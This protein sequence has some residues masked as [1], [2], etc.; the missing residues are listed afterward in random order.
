[1]LYFNLDWVFTVTL[2][3]KQDTSL[4]THGLSPSGKNKDLKRRF[5]LRLF[6]IF[7]LG[8]IIILLAWV[9]ICQAEA[10]REISNFQQNLEK[11]EVEYTFTLL[12]LVRDPALASD[13]QA[14]QSEF[15][16]LSPF[17]KLNST[18][19]LAPNGSILASSQSIP[20]ED[21]PPHSE[22]ILRSSYE[23]QTYWSSGGTHLYVTIPLL[24]KNNQLAATLMNIHNHQEQIDAFRS[25][26]TLR[27]T[28][29]I[30]LN[31]AFLLLVYAAYSWFFLRPL[32]RLDHQARAIAQGAN[33]SLSSGSPILEIQNLDA[34][35]AQIIDTMNE[36]RNSLVSLNQKLEETIAAQNQ[37]L[38][39][40]STTIR[41]RARQLETLNAAIATAS[42]TLNIQSLVRTNL[43]QIIQIVDASKGVIWLNEYSARLGL[44]EGGSRLLL[45]AIKEQ[46]FDLN[47]KVTISDWQGTVPLPVMSLVPTMLNLGIRASITLPIFSG[48]KL[49]GHI[50]VGDSIPRIWR[51]EEIALL[52]IVASQL[53][54]TSER[55]QAIEEVQNHNQLMNTLVAQSELLN[56]PFTPAEVIAAIGQGARELSKA[57]RLAVFVRDTDG[58]VTCPW[59]HNF[60]TPIPVGLLSEPEKST[61]FLGLLK[62]EPIFI[63][64]LSEAVHQ[65]PYHELAQAAGIQSIAAWPLVYKGQ[66]DAFVCCLYH[67]P[68]IWKKSEQEVLE[69]FFRQ[70]SVAMENTRLFEAECAQRRLAEALTEVTST[71]TSTLD[72][73]K[74]LQGILDNLIRV[75]PHHAADIML[76]DNG[77]IRIVRGYGHPPE[78]EKEMMQWVYP[79]KDLFNM[80]EMI[81][82]GKSIVIPD[83]SAAPDWVWFPFSEW[84]RSYA[85]API[86]H[87]GNVLGFINVSSRIPGFFSLEIGPI[88]EAFANQAAISIENARLYQQTQQ[89]VAETS[90]L[91][92]AVLPLFNPKEDLLALARQVT[93]SATHEFAPAHCSLLLVNETHT[94]LNLVA[95]SGY[96]Q[97][98]STTLSL[99]GSGLTVEAAT[100]RKIVYAPDIRKE[101]R[102]V[103]GAKETRSELVIPLIAQDHVIGV[104]NL[105]SPET[106]AFDEN[107]RRILAS[108]AERTALGLE[109]ARLFQAI[110]EHAAQMIYLNDITRI[111]LQTSDSQK[112]LRELTYKVAQMIDADGCYI[113][114]WD[115]TTSSTI[116]LAAYGPKQDNYTSIKPS[117]ERTITSAALQEGHPLV[118]A[119]VHQTPYL[120]AEMAETFPLCSLLALPLVANHQKMGAVLIGFT[121]AHTFMPNEIALGEQAAGQIA[122]AMAKQRS[123]E[124]AQRRAQEAETLRQATMSLT[125]SLELQKVLDNILNHL[126]QV[127]Q[128]DSACVF[129]AEPDYL[130]I[131]SAKNIGNFEEIKKA[132]FP[133]NDEL[134]Q[135]IENTLRP[136]ILP[137]AQADLRFHSWGGITNV[138]SWMGVPLIAGNA[139]V[140]VLT[141]DRNQANA[142][143]TEEM[144]LAQAF[145]NHA[146]IAV[147]NA[148][149]Y[150]ATQQ[151]ARE[152]QALHSAT[153]SLVSTLDLQKLLEEILASARSAIPAAQAA[154]LHLLNPDSGQLQL[155]VSHGFSQREHQIE[156]TQGMQDFWSQILQG[157]KPVMIHDARLLE[158][159]NDLSP[160]QR[161]ERRA[162]AIIAPL[163]QEE[164][165]IGVLS[166]I[167]PDTDAFSETDLRLLV[168]F[169][170]TATA[171]IQNAQLHSA[172][173]HLA[174]TDPLTGVYNRRGFSELA[175]KIICCTKRNQRPLS[176]MM[177]DID[178]FKLVNDRY[179]HDIGDHIL[180]SLAE[181]CQMILRE[182][183]IICRYG[184]EE[185]AVLLP[186]SDVQGTQIA[187]ERLF[188]S[189]AQNP[190]QT[191]CGA[192][193]I[194]LSIGIAGY[195]EKITTL[196]GILK[197]AD[198]AL[199]LAKQEG[200]NRIRIWK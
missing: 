184:G 136:V 32:R 123:L 175:H 197:C 110:R 65:D 64:D 82:T 20:L 71:L 18:Y 117:Q 187:A 30:A 118:V 61:H 129:L 167:S 176:A 121:E 170:S 186:D 150:L 103:P 41:Q 70:A 63:P 84:I 14:V 126:E 54:L 147:E 157:S 28:G 111:A 83:V 53:G 127:I 130:Q 125:S 101:N 178:F 34:A 163:I 35:F 59:A 122:L 133:R 68:I 138:H 153:N 10:R 191:E 94:H 149:L 119:D 174:I 161:N 195:N 77:M 62:A 76:L 26:I 8:D 33:K 49:I 179:G 46:P 155:R 91:Y 154:S 52:E 48:G 67:H 47:Q 106:D 60:P 69:A 81:R 2:Y 139:L 56:R 165:A 45:R 120:S 42:T 173:H 9:A 112:M 115:E 98:K 114:L 51:T 146:A 141:L 159:I 23:P 78:I 38:A 171:A 99:D 162:S 177:I 100:T 164:A 96:F 169:A 19:L 192:I 22:Q 116:P 109:N 95:Q 89:Q 151:R 5:S 6:W 36:Q 135:E 142:F 93:E 152:L 134:F 156:T 4:H 86:C 37:E 185:F 200:R 188:A 1:M 31:L 140:G 73:D 58:S 72:L 180:K 144:E 181:R 43:E 3:S 124:L 92:R 196:E 143:T 87:R 104:L 189:I 80:N 13:W 74:V 132:K 194:T 160:E 85:G 75:V 105:E 15:D 137:D 40:S 11:V 107:T 128:Y 183:D 168:S 50:S 88:L 27:M 182:A 166:L 145:A 79:A 29:F 24:N 44:T 66:V 193:S 108:F 57:D 113:T 198:M 199:Y 21:I 55:F 25:R 17:L 131:W 158:V 16:R 190:F 102:Y 90:A 39:T 7:L 97:P 148:R 12:N 172:V